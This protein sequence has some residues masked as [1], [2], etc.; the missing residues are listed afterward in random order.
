MST[1]TVAVRVRDATDDDD[2]DAL[3]VG[4]FSWWGADKQREL[5]ASGPPVPKTMLV[6][7]LDGV[8][9]GFG[10]GVGAP[11]QAHGYGIA[12]IY[13][14]AHA[15]RRGVGRQ[16][17]EA[18]VPVVRRSG[19][20][21]LMVMVE[22]DD[23]ASLATAGHWGLVDHGHH[24][25]SKL[26]LRA[27]DDDVIDRAIGVAQSRG[28]EISPLTDDTPD[29][30]RAA[31]E[32]LADRFREA[33]DSRDGGGELPYEIFRTFTPEP[34]HVMVARC[35]GVPAGMTAVTERP[36]GERRLNTFFT[37]VHPDHR[38]QSLSTALKATHARLMRDAGW[39]ELW[40]QNMDVN[41]TILA[42][43]ERLGFERVGGYHDMGL[44][45]G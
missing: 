15:R 14:L 17:L 45:F 43:N 16:L 35:D 6:G 27:L 7:E 30:W 19:V 40:T 41:T 22:D 32:F 37:G 28:Y 2:L 29:G 24:F 10:L 8:P 11:I 4:N 44:A 13:V 33:P 9:V 1:S 34:W 38:G 21:G 39:F 5:F 42:A 25:E 18:I 12:T 31:F 23:K 20:P 26:D 36:D 3:N